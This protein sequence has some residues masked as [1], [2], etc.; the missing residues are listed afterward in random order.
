M[1]ILGYLSDPKNQELSPTVFVCLALMVVCAL[2]WHAAVLWNKN[3]FP[4]APAS[5]E[6]SWFCMACGHAFQSD[7]YSLIAA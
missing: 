6:S 5:W 7:Q 1:V 4:M 2:A 3:E